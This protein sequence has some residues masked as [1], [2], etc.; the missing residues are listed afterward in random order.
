MMPTAALPALF[1]EIIGQVCYQTSKGSFPVQKV[2]ILK[3]FDYKNIGRVEG[4]QIE[5]KKLVKDK[6]Q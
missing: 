1:T 4:Y 3:G 6:T 2:A 5:K